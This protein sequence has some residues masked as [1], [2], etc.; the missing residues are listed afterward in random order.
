MVRF[1]PDAAHHGEILPTVG[2]DTSLRNW[3]AMLALDRPLY[4][5]LSCTVKI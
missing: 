2:V 1:C 4:Q 5:F 3:L